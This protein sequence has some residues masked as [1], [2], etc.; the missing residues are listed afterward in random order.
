MGKGPLTRPDGPTSPPEGEVRRGMTS[1]RPHLSPGGEVAAKRRV[2]GPWLGHGGYASFGAIFLQA[3]IRPSTA[4]TDFSNPFC[5][6]ELSE[7]STTRSAPPAP[8][9]TG[10]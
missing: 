2:R 6:E 3:S 4:C 10:T 8:I 5:S 7:I 1:P 9:T